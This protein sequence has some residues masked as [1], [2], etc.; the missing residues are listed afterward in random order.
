MQKFEKIIFILLGILFTLGA[1]F[2]LIGY[3]KPQKAGI[4]VET[5]P[6]ASVFINDVQVGRTPYE[7]TY[8]SGE[9][10]VK[11]VPESQ[12]TP[13][14]PYEIKVT[15]G[16]GI[17]TV[18]RREFDESDESSSGEIVSFEKASAG[19]ISLAVVSV[20]DSARVLVD[21]QSR[22]F[23]PVKVSS[24]APGDH[25]IV[26]SAS[27]YK[28]RTLNLRTVTG[29]KL[30]ALVKLVKN[31]ETQPEVIPTP[32]PVAKTYSVKILDTPG[33]F[34]RVREEPATTAKELAR[35][36][37]GEKFILIEEDV[38]TGWFKIEYLPAQADQEAQQGWVSNQYAQK[39][40]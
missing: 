40:E 25:Q 21:G 7:G 6:A 3:F 29:Y 2:F 15:L 19:E 36:K 16:P 30:T 20:P 39:L 9:V 13:M 12:N 28:D 24:I 34:L 4:L 38:A 18:I 27:G 11:L 10:T 37:P 26:V 8:D 1:A 22:G 32:T 35:V 33:G 23:A 17:K 31:K 14:V 5:I